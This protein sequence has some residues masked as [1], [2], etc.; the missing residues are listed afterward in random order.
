MTQKIQFDG[1]EGLWQAANIFAYRGQ[2]LDGQVEAMQKALDELKIEAAL[3]HTRA[4]NIR[5]AAQALLEQEIS[6]E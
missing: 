1:Q 6:S 4:A 3:A 2:A 5:V